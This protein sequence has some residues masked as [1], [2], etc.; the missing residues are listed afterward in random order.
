MK[1]N[2]NIGAAEENDIR[3]QEMQ[4]GQPI[5]DQ[6]L[7]HLRAWIAETHPDAGSRLPSERD[8]A[9]T[10][11]LSRPELRKSLAALEIEGRIIRQV[12]RGTFTAEPPSMTQTAASL[13]ALAERTA[14]H[15]AMIARLSLEPELARMAALH[16]S[17]LQVKTMQ[18]LGARIRASRSWADYEELDFELHDLIAKSAGNVLLYEL[19]KIMN[20]VRQVVVWRKLTS[21][22][23][24]PS[25][26]Y[27][28]FDEHDAII[29]AIASRDCSAAKDNMRA[30][31]QA[32]LDTLTT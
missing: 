27:H 3:F 30:H 19:H 14:P 17:P 4:N 28:S 31:L 1:F 6:N 9:K 22:I 18:D 20:A 15:D 5:L 11:E 8:L 29:T 2:A 12:G 7:D 26:D 10:L 21:D 16:A 23:K 24:R 13:A 32:T 25:P